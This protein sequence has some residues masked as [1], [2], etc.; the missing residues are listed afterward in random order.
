MR[1]I[2]LEADAFKRLRAISITPTTNIVEVTGDNGSGKTSSLDAIWAALG[3]KDAAPEKPIHTGADKAEVRLVLGENGEAK[4]KVTRRFK[5]KEGGGFTTD[6]VVESAEGARY[7]SPQGVLDAMVGAMC[8]DPLAFTRMRDE[9]QIK[10]LRQFVPGVDFANIEGLNKRDFD[11]RTDLG[12]RLRDLKGQ[13]AAMPEVVGDLPEVEDIGALQAQIGQAA[14]AN[15]EIAT[16]KARREAAVERIEDINDQ[17]AELTK[18]RDELQAKLDAAEPIPEPIDVSAVQARLEK[19]HTARALQE[20]DRAR[21]DVQSRLKATENEELALTAA[22]AK[23][24]DEMAAA[25]QAATMPI[26]G[27]G[28]GDGFV[29]LNGEPFAQAS[30]AEQIRGSVAIAAAMN[31]KLRVARV[32]DGSLLDRKSWAALESYAAEHDLQVWVETVSQHGAA[33]VLIEDGGVVAKAADPTSEVEQVG[34]V[35]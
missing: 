23:R 20:K 24:K 12:R 29:T 9:D 31:P 27:L 3:G 32:M 18:E 11:T 8:F 10:A 35:L 21:R 22:I 2:Q 19:A 25:V 13:L 28:F 1:I 6:L 15:A 17:I 7:P 14:Q 34:D 26:P 4:V 16:R 5:P 33:A 30:R